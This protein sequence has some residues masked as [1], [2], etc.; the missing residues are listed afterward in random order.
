MEPVWAAGHARACVD[1]AGRYIEVLANS[2][3]E[4]DYWEI[5]PTADDLMGW[6]MSAGKVRHALNM[7]QTMAQGDQEFADVWEGWVRRRREEIRSRYK[8]TV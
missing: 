5:D 8:V 7:A 1:I 2:A 6:L 3:R 4:K